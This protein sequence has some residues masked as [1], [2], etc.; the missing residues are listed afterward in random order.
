MDRTTAVTLAN[1]AGSL[2]ALI[3]NSG[4]FWVI[5]RIHWARRV[6]WVVLLTAGLSALYVA[7]Y[8]ALLGFDV[9][10]AEWSQTVSVLSPA[11]WFVVWS[12]LALWLVKHAGVTTVPDALL[13]MIGGDR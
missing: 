2:F 1:M 13:E 7:G 5:R 3:V 12:G 9:P 6:R 4:A 11:A 10:R 8:V